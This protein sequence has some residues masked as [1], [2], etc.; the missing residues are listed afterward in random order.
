[1]KRDPGVGVFLTEVLG[2]QILLGMGCKA[3]TSER[4][5]GSSPGVAET[6]QLGLSFKRCW[7]RYA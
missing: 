6:A 2:D 5:G 3:K 1:V 4:L 7:T